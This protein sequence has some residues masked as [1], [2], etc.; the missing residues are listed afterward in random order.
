RGR[1]PATAPACP[2][3]HR[4]CCGTGLQCGRRRLAADAAAPRVGAPGAPAAWPPMPPAW[5]ALQYGRRAERAVFAVA[6]NG[7]VSA[8]PDRRHTMLSVLPAGGIRVLVA[9]SEH[10]ADAAARRWASGPL[11]SPMVP[12]TRDPAAAWAEN[13]ARRYPPAP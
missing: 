2:A 12:A 4:S 13:A 7:P 1:R 9:A 3:G 10:A 8:R 6:A 11:R 5:P